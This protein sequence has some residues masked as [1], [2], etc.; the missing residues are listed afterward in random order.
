MQEGPEQS[1]SENTGSP[2]SHTRFHTNSVP[3]NFC[4]SPFLQIGIKP[5]GMYR[6][7]CW[8][9]MGPTS[10][11]NG[12][13][14]TVRE[15]P[16]HTIMESDEFESFRE[17]FN[18]EGALPKL[19]YRCQIS[20]SAGNRSM[21]QIENDYFAED[22]PRILSGGK[23][24]VRKLDL[25][26]GN[27]CNIGCVTCG[28]NSSSFFHSEMKRH[29]F[30]PEVYTADQLKQSDYVIEHGQNWHKDPKVWESIEAMLPDLR[31]I[32][33][34]GGEP[35]IIPEVWRLLEKC[36]AMGLSDQ[37]EIRISTNLTS[38]QK[39]HIEIFNQFRF[40]QIFCSI[41][42]IGPTIEYIR[43]PSS[44]KK[45]EA[46]MQLIAE[47]SNENINLTA[48]PVTSI[49]NVWSLPEIFRWRDKYTAKF[50]KKLRVH[51]HSIVYTPLH[52]SIR[53]MPLELKQQAHEN[54]I[55]EIRNFSEVDRKDF[56]RILNYLKEDPVDEEIF[57]S[58][59]TL[60]EGMDKIRKNSWRKIAPQLASAWI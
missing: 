41:D 26:M 7:C 28:P 59:Q 5:T 53:N 10:P 36:I 46:N 34:T 8:M 44:W 25:R 52:L 24:I 45:I 4:V 57:Y 37:L 23:P 43:Y 21:R 29:D 33:L 51:L 35:T 9:D 38:I 3:N 6:S 14:P 42:G 58:G 30:D 39:K 16:P 55:R 13:A 48:T 22:I 12:K 50:G 40:A 54:I 27:T 49:F 19:C 18:R 31:L 17:S 20:E 2:D 1:N 32:Y 15:Y 56:Q 60:V 11:T 47:H